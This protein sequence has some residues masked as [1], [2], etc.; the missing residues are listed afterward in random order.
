MYFLFKS[1][2]L[3]ERNQGS[4]RR[5]ITA[6]QTSEEGRN[7]GL[8]TTTELGTTEDLQAA[9]SNATTAIMPAED[10]TIPTTTMEW[11]SPGPV[12]MTTISNT[13]DDSSIITS[14]ELTTL[15]TT[16]EFIQMTTDVNTQRSITEVMNST[17][18]E[19][20]LI[21]SSGK[22]LRLLF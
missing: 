5:A 1:N 14:T 16:T 10:T 18:T 13:L 4:S 6:F 19:P 17:E 15:E 21:T 3:S 8:E 12:D 20:D 22:P 7:H 9:A 11:T 2:G